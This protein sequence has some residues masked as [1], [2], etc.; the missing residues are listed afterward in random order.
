M[1]VRLADRPEV[2]MLACSVFLLAG[3]FAFYFFYMNKA[4]ETLNELG[5][6]YLANKITAD[7]FGGDFSFLFTFQILLFVGALGIT[8]LLLI[9][10]NQ[11]KE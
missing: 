9:S 10:I 2:V 5:T 11:L 3:S 1:R 8:A 7:L 4:V 6:I